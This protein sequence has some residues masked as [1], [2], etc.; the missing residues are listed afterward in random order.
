MKQKMFFLLILVAVLLGFI[1]LTALLTGKYLERKGV[2]YLEQRGFDDYDRYLKERDPVL[3]WPIKSDYANLDKSGA[4]IIP[5]YPD[6]DRF[7]SCISTYGDSFTF[8]SD[9]DD[10]H[11]WTN[12]LS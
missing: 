10:E 8:G 3:G 1:E 12:I 4:R 9:V 11:A 7:E 5:S 2:F 6:P